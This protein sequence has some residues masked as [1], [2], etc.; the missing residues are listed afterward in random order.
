MGYSVRG[1]VAL[2]LIFSGLSVPALAQSD[3]R[4]NVQTVK[5]TV[6][7][8][9]TLDFPEE[10]FRVSTDSA[11]VA[12][13]A[14]LTRRELLIKAKTVGSVLVVVWCEDGT[15]TRYQVTVDVKQ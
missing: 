3:S 8:S 10:V 5:L 13:V 7:D 4:M 15:R 12:S 14:P 1:A 6:G 2:G 11:D 9:K